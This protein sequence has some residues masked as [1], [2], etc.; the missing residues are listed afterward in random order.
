MYCKSCGKYNPDGVEWCK[1]CGGELSK[2]PVKNPVKEVYEDKGSVGFWL[3][4]LLGFLGLLIGICMYV[5]K[6]S[7]IKT[8]LIGWVKGYVI[9][10]VLSIVLVALGYG[11]LTAL[12]Y[13]YLV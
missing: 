8:F 6:E 5:G 9:S 11:C 3:G 10:I 2:Y 13:T 4:L 1:Y 12:G 7:A